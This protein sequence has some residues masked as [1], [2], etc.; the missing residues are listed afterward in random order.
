MADN[1]N[2]SKT[3]AIFVVDIR[4]TSYFNKGNELAINLVFI[5]TQIEPKQILRRNFQF[6]T[7]SGHNEYERI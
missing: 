1:G 2:N 4:K 3:T 7:T 5:P 6:E